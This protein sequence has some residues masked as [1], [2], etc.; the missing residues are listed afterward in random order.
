MNSA[1]DPRDFLH[2][3]CAECSVNTIGTPAC[4]PCAPTFRKPVTALP[5]RN[6]AADE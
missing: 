6:V 3:I 4:L 5:K 2:L 1:F